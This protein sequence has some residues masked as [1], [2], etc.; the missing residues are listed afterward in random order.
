[1]LFRRIWFF[2]TRWRRIQD[3]DDEIRSLF[4]A[5]KR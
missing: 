4:A 3:L 1:M 5:L 2:V